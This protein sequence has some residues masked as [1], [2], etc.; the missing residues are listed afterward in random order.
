MGRSEPVKVWR[1]SV[2]EERQGGG[3]CRTA[4]NRACGVRKGE[5]TG[6]EGGDLNKRQIVW[7]MGSPWEIRSEETKSF[8]EY[9]DD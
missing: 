5:V 6:E 9:G 1:E 7:A 2:Q 3:P 8:D 4:G